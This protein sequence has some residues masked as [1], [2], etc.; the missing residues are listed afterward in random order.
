MGWT[1]LRRGSVDRVVPFA[2]SRC[3]RRRSPRSGS[4]RA[5]LGVLTSAVVDSVDGD[6]FDAEVVSVQVVVVEPGGQGGCSFRVRS[7]GS[8]VGSLCREGAVE[9]LGFAVGP[10]GATV[11]PPP[12]AVGEAAQL[13]HVD[14][15][16]RAG[17]GVLVALG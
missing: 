5:G 7:G 14:V 3:G 4:A 10:G 13:L 17:V 9:A 15:D 6:A 16:Q 8:G 11:R 2:S 12:T 1:P